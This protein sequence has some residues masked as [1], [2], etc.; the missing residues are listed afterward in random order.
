MQN[1]NRRMVW[2]V[3]FSP[4]GVTLASGGNDET[5]RL[6]DVSTDKERA[7]LTGHA[8]AVRS[9]A[10]SPDGT[11][12]A[13]GGSDKTVSL[14]DV[15]AAEQ[16]ARLTGHTGAVRSV[17]FS[18]D[19]TILASGGNDGIV[20]AWD[21][22]T[23]EQ[24][25]RL[26][27]H[28]GLVWSV[29]FSPDGTLASGGADETVRLWDAAS[30]VPGRSLA[31]VRSDSPSVQDLLG[32][33]RDVEALADLIAATDTRPPLAIALIGDWGIGKSSVMLQ[34]QHRINLLARMSLNNPGLTAFAA[35]IRQVRFNAWHYSDDQLW[36][37][38][39]SHLFQT[40][41]APDDQDLSAERKETP[42][43]RRTQDGRADLASIQNEQ[44]E[45]RR[46]VTAAQEKSTR[47]AKEL[48]AVDQIAQ[49]P[50]ALAGLRSPLHIAWL[51]KIA[52]RVTIRHVQTTVSVLVSWAAVA[53]A[54]FV[55]WYFFGSKS[56]AAVSA[57]AAV[58]AP[59]VLV[60]RAVRQL[61]DDLRGA[62]GAEQR[63]AQQEADKL[64]E[65]Q[66][67]IDAA[68][69]LGAFHDEH[70]APSAYKEHR[71]LLGQVHEDLVQLSENLAD[72][73]AEW[74]AS[75]SVTS[76]PLE[77]IVLY[78]DDLDRCPPRRVVE[79]L[80]AVHLMLALDLFV[81]VVA[82]DARWLIRSLNYYHHELFSTA[83]GNADLGDEDSAS[84]ATPIDYLDKIFQIPYTLVPPAAAA[85]ATYLRAILPIGVPAARSA[86]GPPVPQAE[87]S[88]GA[89]RPQ[90]ASADLE[91]TS[92]AGIPAARHDGNLGAR[93]SS[94][95]P[96]P[97]EGLLAPKEPGS[98]MAEPDLNPQSLQLTPAEVE[99]MARLGGLVP[100]P[101]PPSGWQTSIGSCVSASPRPDSLPSPATGIQALI[102]PCRFYW[103]SWPVV[104]PWLTR[105]SGGYLKLLT[106][107]TS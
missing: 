8:G 27:G 15:S 19:G 79:V 72:A 95:N 7:R 63:E 88:P 86:P 73:R 96:H 93:Y 59:V 49:S 35:T 53:A 87:D 22:G 94:G 2:S 56:G 33:R 52:A 24:R 54:A 58:T 100:N 77:R 98:T 32:V 103:P 107:R 43:A 1:H 74:M 81:V 51:I 60:H 67:L 34:V 29:A 91:K 25:I 78:I 85:T 62:L 21:T 102:R 65:R 46:K 18:P 47:L 3:A 61:T 92:P 14:W 12:L 4:D 31:G 45:L 6:W 64:K 16:R 70:G 26:T 69:R 5:V 99:F 71:G 106:R 28:A 37:G 41:A 82:V 42:D 38:L 105:S 90:R 89:D 44:A 48:D 10:F 40:L 76:P 68:A 55:A 17:A 50:G 101:R 20:R 30:G 75:G 36:A 11:T 39:V 66:L 23:G 9:V 104:P 13:T 57:I 80:E 84:L 97:G 83:N